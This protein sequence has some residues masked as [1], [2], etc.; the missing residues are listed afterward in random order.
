MSG[1]SGRTA[2]VTGATGAIAEACALQLA[3]DG[4]RLALMARRAEGLAEVAERI[5]AQ[6]PG[7]EVHTFI[8]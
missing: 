7:A 5:R 4:A 2:F 3:R 6:V 8:G 1:L